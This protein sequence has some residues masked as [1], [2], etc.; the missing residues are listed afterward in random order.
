MDSTNNLLKLENHYKGQR[1]FIIGS[2]PSLA[3]KDLSFLK[4]E[5]TIGLNLSFLHM[6]QWSLQP[7]FNLVADKY[8]IPEF[9][10]VFQN[11]IK[12]KKTKKVIIASACETFPEDLEDN[13]TYFVPKK[14]PQDAINF[15]KNPVAEGFWRGKTVAFDA[16]QFAYFLGFSEVYIIGMDLS[17]N[18]DW[19][20]NG[21]C[22]ELQKNRKFPNLIFPKTESHIIQRGFPGHPEYFDLISSYMQKARESFE[23]AGRHVYNDSRSSTDVF[24]KID[25]LSK[26]GHI[27]KIVAFVPSKGTSSRVRGK[28]IR[29]LGDK[30]LFLHILDT[31][32][33]SLTI[34][35]VYLDTESDEVFNLAKGRRHH[36]LRRPIELASNKTD[37]NHL[38]LYEASCVPDADIYVQALPT[39]PFLSRETIDD[40]VFELIRAPN[41][42]SVFAAS[43]QKLYLWNKNC[44]PINY[45]PKNI[46]NSFEL[47]DTIIE[48][49]SLYAIRK[50]ALAL[51]KSRI[52]K[53]PLIFRV[54]LIE[55]IDINSEED[56]QLA[57]AIYR[58]LN[59]GGR[60]D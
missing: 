48:A 58:G 23:G 31:L 57:D 50:E 26:F 55:S 41:H 60:N 53:K 6:D 30:P 7:T 25:I 38:L 51:R 2:G 1:V 3:Y 36:E 39:A 43:M 37:G 12:D 29:V 49:M 33:S 5:S 46:P 44:E 14:L 35:N 18:H 42:D 16:L 15:S 19:G 24:E 11:L 10:E 22:Y 20:K 32:L 54:P 45:D 52:G 9:K 17:S 34:N 28:N 27:P 59:S 4:N 40:A 47:A 13:Q 8:I 21:H 56:F